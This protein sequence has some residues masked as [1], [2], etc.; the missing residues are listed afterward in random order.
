M[1]LIPQLVHAEGLL[2]AHQLAQPGAG[3]AAL[4]VY[5]GADPVDQIALL[6]PDI[7][8]QEALPHG[9]GGEEQLAQQGGGGLQ[10][11]FSLQGIGVV[12][13]AGHKADTLGLTLLADHRLDGPAIQ[14]V[15]GGGEGLQIRMGGSAPAEHRGDQGVGGRGLPL[16]RSHHGQPQIRAFEFIGVDGAQPHTGH[17]FPS[18]YLS[19]RRF[20]FFGV[21]PVSLLL[22][23]WTGECGLM[24]PD[25]QCGAG[26]A[27]TGSLCPRAGIGPD[28]SAMQL[29]WQIL[30]H[31]FLKKQRLPTGAQRRTR[32][33]SGFGCQI[34]VCVVQ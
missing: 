34:P 25:L 14:L 9:P 20:P 8:G 13:K 12:Q 18:C 1:G 28:R 7:V 31:V 33:F 19:H 17:Q 21:L 24:R 30:Y 11:G 29:R 23:A 22:L 10:D 32:T 3:I 26:G 6:L 2:A 5:L 15:Q 4:V 16:Q 27:S